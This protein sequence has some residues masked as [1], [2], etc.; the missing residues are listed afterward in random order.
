M[1]P[2]RL[3]A[4]ALVMVLLAACSGVPHNSPPLVISSVGGEVPTTNN[5]ISPHPGDDPRSI[6]AG[7]LKAA[8]ASSPTDA[9]HSGSRQFLTPD[10]GSKWNDG[11]VTV[12]A[13]YSIQLPQLLGD[14][15]VVKVTGVNQGQLDIHGVYT[16]SLKSADSGATS[17][18]T[19]NLSKVSGQWRINGLAPGVLVGL[20]DFQNVYSA[21]VLY[22]F[23][24]TESRL[25]P[26]LRYSQ[27]SGEPLAQ[28]MLAQMLTGPRPELAQ[29]VQN[30]IPDQVDPRRATITSTD[31]ITLDLP[32][33]AQLDG[34]A[35][36]RLAGQLA[37]TFGGL[38]I[39]GV[40]SL[41]DAGHPVDIPGYGTKFNKLNLP[42][43]GPQGVSAVV[44]PYYLNDGGLISGVDFKRVPGTVGD[45]K[46]SLDSMALRRATTG[47]LRI[48]ARTSSNTVVVGPASGPLTTV[49]LPAGTRSRPDWEPHTSNAW[50]AVGSAI[51][52][53][54]AD[55][56]PQAVPLPTGTFSGGQIVSLRFSPDGVRLAIVVQ[57]VDGSNTLWIGSVVR[58][59]GSV[60]LDSVEPISGPTLSVSDVAWA[61]PIGLLMIAARTGEHAK[62]WAVQSDG[63]FPLVRDTGELPQPESIAAAVDQPILL[64]TSGRAVWVQRN[65]VWTSLSGGAQ[66]TIGYAPAYAP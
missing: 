45:G 3:G 10:A 39:S 24:S 55:L 37:Y 43:Y 52:R 29:S 66:A 6:V 17:T 8:V 36:Q 25:V 30:E 12:L 61:D 34:Q 28:W 63:S 49:R 26:D 47:E 59:S 56:R 53:F 50:V 46:Y 31:Q 9:R 13:D 65:L 2:I 32:G 40:V 44:Q 58:S 57:G 4:V 18:Y 1:R 22:F 62:V 19:F 14:T 60:S 41:D 7:F 54:G 16:P 38:L 35:R 51:Y 48:V 23:D 27:L 21:R 42:D 5:E 15:A 11:N 20:A 33:S 64:A